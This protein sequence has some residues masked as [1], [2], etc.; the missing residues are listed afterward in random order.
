MARCT[1]SALTLYSPRSRTL[2][3]HSNSHP[4]WW[5]EEGGL[6]HETS[7]D[8]ALHVRHDVEHVVQVDGHVVSRVRVLGSVSAKMA[9]ISSMSMLSA[10]A[11]VAFA[12]AACN[13]RTTLGVSAT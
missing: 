3:A 13:S 1:L 4:N 6:R 7:E 10:S 11:I 2:N 8:R 5:K 9:I 12:G